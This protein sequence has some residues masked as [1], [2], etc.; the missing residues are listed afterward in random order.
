MPSAARTYRFNVC[1]LTVLSFSQEVFNGW[2]FINW[3]YSSP[4]LETRTIANPR[5]STRINLIDIGVRKAA[6]P[7]RFYLPHT[8][9][10]KQ[11]I[12]KHEV[13]TRCLQ[14]VFFFW[15]VFLSCSLLLLPP[16][17]WP[18]S[19]VIGSIELCIRSPLGF[20][21]FFLTEKQ[22]RILMNFLFYSDLIAGLFIEKDGTR[23]WQWQLGKKL[24][25]LL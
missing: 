5:A 20:L 21:Y 8:T 15:S 12:V 7:D 3:S 14:L 22:D 13:K 1:T 4:R 19:S 6:R 11:G 16:S 10:T 2:G 18:I 25:L 23:Y 24:Q 17:C 9:I